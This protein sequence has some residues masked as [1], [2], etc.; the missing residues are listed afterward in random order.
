MDLNT[1]WD[2]HDRTEADL[3]RKAW[4]MK[5]Q[6]DE[7]LHDTKIHT[8]VHIPIVVHIKPNSHPQG[9]RLQSLL[10]LILQGAHFH[11]W[12]N[13]DARYVRRAPFLV[14]SQ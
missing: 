1:F 9:K 14:E 13:E 5:Q 11:V 10:V 8:R 2:K 6:D 12:G 3:S 4:H 7:R